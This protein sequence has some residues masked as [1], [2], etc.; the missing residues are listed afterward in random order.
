[1]KDVL[2][3]LFAYG[4]NHTDQQHIIGWSDCN[5][6]LQWTSSYWLCLLSDQEDEAKMYV[7]KK[8]AVPAARDSRLPLKRLFSHLISTPSR[9]HGMHSKDRRS[10][11]AGIE[12]DAKFTNPRFKLFGFLV[13]DHDELVPTAE[14]A[15][16]AAARGGGPDGRRYECHYCCRAFANSQALGGHQNA[17]KK[18]RQQ[19]R[20]AQQLHRASLHLSP[21]PAADNVH[22]HRRAASAAFAQ[23][24]SSWVRYSV[25]D[26]PATRSSLAARSILPSSVPPPPYCSTSAKYCEDGDL[27]W[28]SEACRPI[29]GIRLDGSTAAEGATEDVYGLDLHLSLAPTGS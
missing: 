3:S 26:P 20:L 9:V 22:Y 6:A 19:L 4:S 14:A 25:P 28:C 11:M 2:Q 1:M 8:E 21:A 17:H 7:P 10:I 13:S 23:L 5:T 16:D 27:R 18:E 24:R 29:N 15:G 12:C